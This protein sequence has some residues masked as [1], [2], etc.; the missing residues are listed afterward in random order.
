MP[1]VTIGNDVVIGALSIVTKDVPSNSVVAGVPARVLCSIEE[2]MTKV[3]PEELFEPDYDYIAITVRPKQALAFQA[4]VY[5]QLGLSR[6]SK[7]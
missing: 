6:G 3:K 7:Q 4:K 1:G 2:Y 5:K